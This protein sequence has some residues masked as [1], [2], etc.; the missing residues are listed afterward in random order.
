V[1]AFGP[2]GTSD[3]DNPGRAALAIAGNPATPWHSSWYTTPDFG[4]LQSGT[5]LLADMGRAV[6]VTSVRLSLGGGRGADIQ[7]RAGS[8]PVSAALHRV[9][10]ASGAGG[11]VQF[12]LNTPVRARYLLVWFT[13]L[14]PDSKGTYQASVYDITVRGRR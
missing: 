2:A 13:R 5:G 9:A 4:H 1:A 11:T 8:K 7:L 12:P 14:P 6:T 10:G 3:G